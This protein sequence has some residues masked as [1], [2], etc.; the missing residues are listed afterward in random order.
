[1]GKYNFDT[2]PC[3]IGTGA[4]K[5]DALSELF[6][7]NDLTPLWIADMEF[8]IAPQITQ[9]LLNR[10]NHPVYGY[11]STPDSYWQ[12]IID[13]LDR[14]HK[15]HTTR[16]ELTFVPGVVRAIAYAINF[17]TNQGDK[18]VIQPPV[19]H[20]FR[21]VTE[22]NNRKVIENPLVLSSDGKTYT[23][24]LDGLEQ[25]F[26]NEHPKLMILC[27]P[28]NPAGIQWSASTLAAVASLARK[29][30]VIIVSDEIHGDLMLRKTPHIP[31]LS[32][33][34]DA[35]AVGIAFGAPSKTFNIPG[36]VSSWAVVKNPQLRQP[37]YQWL[38][39]NEFSSPNFTATIGT[40]TA[41]NTAES[42]LDE[43][44]PYLEDNI[45]AVDEF[46]RSNCP[47]IKAIKPQAS[48][49]IWLDCRDLGLSQKALVDLFVNKAHL[50]LNDGTMFGSQGT[51]FMRLNIA[52]PR[53]D[54]LNALNAIKDAV[55][56]L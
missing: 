49:L 23:M 17:F 3:R 6:G 41:Y 14:R 18:V 22:G 30:N 20:P 44:I 11:A 45:D 33:S 48:F 56:D 28:H 19:Y 37:F 26:A 24:D 32:V 1:M 51:G 35:R 15:F 52:M 27:N 7:R 36:L 42:W 2:A 38:E 47:A 43:L 10:Y 50:A 12:S 29:N 39:V 34:D 53:K 55:S 9:A 31:F 46:L 5:Y 8:S 4:M 40:E 25:I 16:E 54:L 21:I 13:W